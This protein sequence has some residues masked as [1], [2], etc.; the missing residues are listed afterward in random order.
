VLFLGIAGLLY[1]SVVRKSE[2]D[3]MGLVLEVK[4]GKNGVLIHDKEL[5]K[6]VVKTIG[7]QPERKSIQKINSRKL[8]SDLEKDP[9]I[10][11]A[12]VYFDSKNRLHVVVEPK[13]VVLRIS[14]AT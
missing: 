3:V 4:S 8:E 2:A 5:K 1:L 14:D 10:K 12:E 7:F 9:R 11:N 13:E 6:L